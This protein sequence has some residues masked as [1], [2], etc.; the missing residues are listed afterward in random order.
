MYICLFG[1]SF[2]GLL[3]YCGG[4]YLDQVKDLI[5]SSDKKNIVEIY[6]PAG[7]WHWAPGAHTDPSTFVALYFPFVSMYSFFIAALILIK[8]IFATMV[9]FWPDTL[10]HGVGGPKEKLNPSKMGEAIFLRCWVQV[11]KKHNFDN[12]TFFSS[13][14]S[15]GPLHHPER[16]LSAENSMIQVWR[17]LLRASTGPLKHRHLKQFLFSQFLR[18]CVNTQHAKSL[19]PAT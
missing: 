19:F 5:C 2:Q 16:R 4:V 6:I 10:R 13:G 15:M 17:K 3:G 11:E 9:L 1:V 18:L 7:R 12:L 14:S 8:W